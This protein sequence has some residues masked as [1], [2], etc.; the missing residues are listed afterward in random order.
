MAGKENVAVVLS[1]LAANF[2][3]IRTF[4]YQ[5]EILRIGNAVALR[6][7]DMNR[8]SGD[9]ELAEG[10]GTSAYGRMTVCYQRLIV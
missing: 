3:R 8:H 5:G 7:R 4:N 9:G 6:A 2:R 10:K 1:I